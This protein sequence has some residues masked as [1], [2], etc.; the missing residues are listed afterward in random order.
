MQPSTSGDLIGKTS[1][2]A[3]P[4]TLDGSYKIGAAAAANV[5]TKAP[6]P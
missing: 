2:G 6:P 3:E 4:A 1:S 5:Y